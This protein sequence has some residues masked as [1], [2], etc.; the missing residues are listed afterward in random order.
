MSRR[1][2]YPACFIAWQICAV[3]LYRAEWAGLRTAA[4]LY[5]Q[6]EHDRRLYA[7][8]PVYSI[9]EAA[10][11]LV[12]PS[13]TVAFVN[14]AIDA[15]GTFYEFKAKYYLWPRSVRFVTA[16]RILE[17]RAV[18]EADAILLFDPRKK[19]TDLITFLDGRASFTKAYE[20]SRGRSYQAVYLQR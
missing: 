17:E 13:G 16:T 6:S 9:L 12:P 11:A 5:G 15:D 2:L 14:P 10:Q 3:P 1:W 7:D 8:G 4:G 19:P 20:L 18:P